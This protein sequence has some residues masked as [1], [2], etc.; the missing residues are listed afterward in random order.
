MNAIQIDYSKVVTRAEWLEARR[1]LLAK[2]KDLTRAR[3]RL[4]ADRRR[5][6]MVEIDKP[7]VFEGPDGQATLLDLFE[8]RHQLIVYH[9]MWRW[10]NG[11]PLDEG[12][13]SCSAWTDEL[14]RG[15]LNSLRTRGTNF[16]LVSRA[17]LEKLTAFKKRMGWILPWHSS[18]G[19]DFNYD[20][21]VTQDESIAP[22]EYN[23]KTKAEHQRDGTGYY[24]EGEQPFDLPGL[25]C[26]LR[27]GHKV[28]H[29]YS[30]YG[31]GGEAV[32]GSHYLL[33]LTALGRQEEWEKRMKDDL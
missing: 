19:S 3:D 8:G 5:L 10:K 28:Y 4:N 33:D 18:F 7:Y 1:S 31:R 23:Y 15:H 22:L 32:G 25:S 6:P 20:F 26:F 17:P 9:F 12:C 24:F 11:E 14:T 29:T 21:H 2:E 27:R 16:C 30:T 13:P